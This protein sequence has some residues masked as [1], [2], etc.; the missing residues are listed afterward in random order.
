MRT[1]SNGYTLMEMLVVLFIVGLLTVAAGTYAF[2]PRQKPAVQ[3]ILG[4]VEGLISEAHKYSS[5]TLG[6][7][8]LNASGSWSSR[9]Y[10]LNYQSISPVGAASLP[11]NSFSAAAFRDWTYAGVDDQNT[12]GTAVGAETLAAAMG[13][14]SP[15]I[16]V[17]LNAALANPL[18]GTK[19]VQINPFNKQFLTPFCIPV[20]GIRGGATYAGAPVGMV[21]VTG[22]RI[23][24]FYKAGTGTDNPWRRM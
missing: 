13:N 18:V 1:R 9:S 10:T 22:N 6:T 19:S 5:A 7:V 3:S 24:K 15:D 8:R 21:V 11:L 17:E 16:Q 4:E 23:Y 14:I 12:M 20:V 2:Q